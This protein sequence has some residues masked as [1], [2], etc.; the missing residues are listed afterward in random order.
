MSNDHG[1]RDK[2]TT[3]LNDEMFNQFSKVRLFFKI[4]HFLFKILTVCKQSLADDHNLILILRPISWIPEVEIDWFL[5]GIIL[6]FYNQLCFQ[7]KSVYLTDI[8]C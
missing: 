7:K 6:T 8:F 3:S 4:R 1:S 5:K 2:G